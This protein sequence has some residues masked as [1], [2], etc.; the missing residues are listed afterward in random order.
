[1]ADVS[2]IGSTSRV[3]G[4]ITGPVDLEIQ[5]FVEGE[6]AVDGDVVVEA[7]ALVAASIQARSIVVRGAIRGDLTVEEAVI[8]EDGARVVGDVRAQRVVIAP[9]AF[10]RGHVQTAGV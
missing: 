9:G 7:R 3:H 1:M 8:L 4:R 10:L 5:G 6:V 2:V